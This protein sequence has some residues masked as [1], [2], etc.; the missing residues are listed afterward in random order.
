MFHFYTLRKYKTLLNDS[1]SVI[2]RPLFYVFVIGLSVEAWSGV[3]WGLF[4]CENFVRTTKG[5]VLMIHKVFVVQ[6]FM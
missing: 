2:K 3:L 6:N 1:H 5:K 4:P